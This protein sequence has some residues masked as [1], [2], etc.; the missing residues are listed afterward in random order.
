MEVSYSV[1]EH[2]DWLPWTCD[3]DDVL[4]KL[5]SRFTELHL[6]RLSKLQGEWLTMYPLTKKH[7]DH[8]HWREHCPPMLSQEV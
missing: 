1:Q 2:F 5:L 6:T 4:G 3:E 7:L 8:S